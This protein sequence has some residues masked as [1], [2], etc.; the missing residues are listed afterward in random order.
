MALSDIQLTTLRAACFATPAAAAFFV[1]PGN[2]AGLRT[3]LNTASSFVVWRT[4]VL[5]DE[6]MQNGFDWVRVDNLSVG[7]ARI[8]DWL[9][10]NEGRSINPSKANV[11]AGIQECW[12]GTAADLLVQAAVLDHCK[13][14]ATNAERLLGS[15]IGD[16]ANP[17]LLSFEGD[18]SDVDA[19]RL[20][21]RD[22]GTVWT[23]I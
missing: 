14:N 6:I 21:Y 19:A 20:I 15:G 13:R 8:W 12:K 11:R 4:A 17:G 18:L 3:Y 22:N 10:D 5:Q 7:K 23:E 2:A 16:A 1:N 9:F